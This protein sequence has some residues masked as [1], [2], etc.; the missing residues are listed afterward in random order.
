HSLHKAVAIR[1]GVFQLVFWSIIFHTLSTTMFTLVCAQ[2]RGHVSDARSRNSRQCEK[3]YARSAKI[4]YRL[5]KFLVGTLE[6][7]TNQQS[8]TREPLSSDECHG[9]VK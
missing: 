7:E 4:S 3:K 5:L 8:I 9:S 6:A 2:T 1:D